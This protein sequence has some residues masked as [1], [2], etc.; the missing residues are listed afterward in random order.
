MTLLQR[1]INHI[2]KLGQPFPSNF[3][4]NFFLKGIRVSLDIDHSVSVPRTFYLLYKTLH[5]F[6]IDQSS[7]LIQELLK[8]YFYQFFFSWSY[9]IRD[10]FIALMFYQIEY[11]YIM[12]TT[13]QLGIEDSFNMETGMKKSISMNFVNT[14]IDN[15]EQLK[16]ARKKSI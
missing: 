4:F 3:D 13:N 14:N 5:F 12:K 7:I 11:F 15:K 2:E 8:K 6:P 10:V 16:I 9:N 1:W